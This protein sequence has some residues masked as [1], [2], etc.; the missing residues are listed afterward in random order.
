MKYSGSDRPDLD[1]SQVRETVKLLAVSAAQLEGGMKMSDESVSVLTAS[2]TGMFAELDAIARLLQD[3]APGPER[4]QALHYCA[5]AR[6]QIDASIVA[7]Q[8][9]DRLQ[10]RLQH[11]GTGLRSLSAIVESPERLY[12]PGEW[13]KLQNDIRERYT[14]EAEKRMFDAIHEGKT[15]DEALALSLP[16]PQADDDVELF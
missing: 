7:F 15:I 12:N 3:L 5:N 11:V 14:M 4:D 1:W 9:Y 13:R 2:F 10:Q 8:F 16:S 6:S